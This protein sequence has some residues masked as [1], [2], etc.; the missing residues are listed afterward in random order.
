M[1]QLKKYVDLE[2]SSRIENLHVLK[3]DGKVIGQT[4]SFS[5]RDK[6]TRQIVVVIPSLN[7][8]GYGATKA[9]AEKMLQFSLEDFLEHLIQMPMTQ[10][11]SELK[12]LGW[13][14]GSIKSEDF[15][16]AYVDISGALKNFNA[17]GNEV[18]EKLMHI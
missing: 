1:G 12:K 7:L 4:R 9:K 5:F 17:V 16:K 14:H 11:V 15:S 10:I 8:S 13:K 2:E 18:Q 6:D 3:K